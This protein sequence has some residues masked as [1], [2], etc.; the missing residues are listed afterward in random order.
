MH[1][2]R[3]KFFYSNL[4]AL[5]GVL[6]DFCG[7]QCKNFIFNDFKQ[8]C[9]FLFILIIKIFH[10]LTYHTYSFRNY[11]K[12]LIGDIIG[13]FCRVIHHSYSLFEFI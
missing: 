5:I 4:H 3:Y 8:I 10:I 2:S 9:L 13:L 11:H 7:L 12:R 1:R 6:K